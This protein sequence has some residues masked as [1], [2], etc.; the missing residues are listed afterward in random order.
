VPGWHNKLAATLLRSLPEPLV[1]SVIGRASKKY[2]L[3][4]KS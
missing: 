1:R 3:D 4:A 2:V